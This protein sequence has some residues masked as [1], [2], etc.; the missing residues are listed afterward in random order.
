LYHSATVFNR[1]YYAQRGF[2]MVPDTEEFATFV[3]SL[4][5]TSPFD[6]YCEPVLTGSGEID[7]FR[8]PEHPDIIARFYSL[9]GEYTQNGIKIV[10]FTLMLFW[11]LELHDGEYLVLHAR[12]ASTEEKNVLYEMNTLKLNEKRIIH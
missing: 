8:H 7:R 10:A 9:S 1:K 6:I 5:D 11:C 12:R 4:K 2:F 3:E